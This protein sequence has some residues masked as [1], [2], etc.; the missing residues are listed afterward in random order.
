[1]NKWEWIII[2]WKNDEYVYEI[3]EY[4]SLEEAENARKEMIN[5][6]KDIVLYSYDDYRS[7]RLE[8]IELALRGTTY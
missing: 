7:K 1:M 8:P 6:D 3:W 5:E 4:E 2:D